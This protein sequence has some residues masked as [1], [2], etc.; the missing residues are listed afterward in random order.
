MGIL[1]KLKM[2]GKAEQEQRSLA[3]PMSASWLGHNVT[4]TGYPV[5]PFLAENL[6]T[7]TACVGAISSAVASLPALVYRS[8]GSGRVELPQHPLARLIQA[9]A[10][11]LT[12]VD[13]CE[14]VISSVLLHGNALCQIQS[15]GAGRVTALQPIPW[16]WVVPL[17]LPNGKLVFDIFEPMQ[18]GRRLLADEVFHLKDRSD[19]ALI[20]RSRLSRAPDAVGNAISLQQFALHAWQNQGSPSGAVQVP[21]PLSRDNYQTLSGRLAQ[22]VEGTANARKVLILDNGIQWQSISVSPEDAE[23]LASRRFSVEELCR[24]YQVPPPI[25]QDYT[26]NTFTNSAQASLWFAQFTLAPWIRK[27]EAEFSRSVIIGNDVSLE[28]DMSALVRGDFQTRWQSYAIAVQNGILSVD[29]IRAAEGYGPKGT[30]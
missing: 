8:V 17:V 24:L 15:D 26:H 18:Q 4:S 2:F 7:V 6:A 20:G 22:H 3:Y 16:P 10:N 19:N 1:S 25:V 23:V 12:W 5:S 28:I 30:A 29:E 9:P 27:L 11:M 21:G 14:W 13:W